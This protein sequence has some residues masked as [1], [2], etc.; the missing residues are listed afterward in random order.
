MPRRDPFQLLRLGRLA[1]GGAARIAVRESRQLPVRVLLVA[2][3]HRGRARRLEGMR[4][5]RHRLK[6]ERHELG[7]LTQEASDRLRHDTP[8]LR[9][10]APLD[11]HLEVELLAREPLQRVL[12][13]GAELVLVDVAQQA[14][15]EIGIAEAPGVVVAQHA[16]D[17]G[18]GQNFAH[19]VEDRIVV[20]RVADLLEL[21]KQP[22]E[23]AALNRV[24]RDE[25]ED[26]AVLALAVA[27]DAAHPLLQP[28][29]VPR[30][31][32]VEQDVADLKVDAFAGGL[33]GDQNLDRA[34]AELLLGVQARARLVARARLH[35]AVDAADAE[36]PG[37][38]SVDEIVQRVLELGE[39]K[40]A[41]IGMVEEALASEAAP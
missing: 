1:V 37:L 4:Q 39:E 28:V 6:R 35:A 18:G 27:V 9:P 32:V 29:R 20:Q 25:V 8:L 40:Q 26:Q 41:L 30:D 5:A 17:V 12:A 10:R 13:D 15:F 19:D 36:A 33:G 11:Q 14:V 23:N 21:F 7:R 31:V 34:F 24:G 22:L 16:L 3:Q 2:A 38:Q